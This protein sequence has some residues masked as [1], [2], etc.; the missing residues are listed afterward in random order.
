[1]T[2]SITLSDLAYSVKSA[3]YIGFPESV[4]VVAEISEL[5]VNKSGHC[6]IELI[7]KDFNGDRIIA[8]MRATAWANVYRNIK[9]FFQNTTGY[10]LGAGIK[11]M[12]L[13]Q[14]EFHEI[15][16]LSLN[17]RDIDPSYTL[18]DI[19]RRKQEVIRKLREEGIIDMNKALKFPLVPQRLAIIS[20][21]TAAGYGD[22]ADTLYKN[23]YGFNFYTRLY[24]AIM[25]GDK[26]ESSIINALDMIFEDEI[27]FD[28]VVIIRGGGAQSE[29]DSFNSYQLA[30][31]IC[32]FPLPVITGI[33]HE[34]DDT[35]ADLVANISL[36]TPTAVG[37]FIIS[38][39][40]DFKVRIEGYLDRI[41]NQ[42]R[43]IIPEYYQALDKKTY[44]LSILLQNS[45]N[46][47]LN[48]ISNF[49]LT[50]P[51]ACL[52][53]INLKRAG[54]SRSNKLFEI[55]TLSLIKQYKISLD[56]F[57]SETRK[58]SA[59]FLQKHTGNLNALERN[60]ENLSPEKT[61]ER[62]FTITSLNGK[63]VKSATLLKKGEVIDTMFSDGTVASRVEEP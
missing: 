49:E 21:E 55:H 26:S 3:I 57:S 63:I 62:G 33:G 46:S 40:L 61:L 51:K 44:E 8:R 60:L 13:V 6:Y 59:A 10:I 23:N 16:G 17:I 20:S 50:L 4:W 41:I 39:M 18:G 29:L 1:M 42:T 5:N 14:V 58:Y 35:I 28:A 54:L 19:A 53:L 11:V 2:D 47:G 12:L 9:P 22:F 34:R 24:P 52:Q 30:F 37:E 7:E 32:Q 56:T 48:R 31:H 38:R 25:Q 43:K 45:I 27:K 36:K 15:Y